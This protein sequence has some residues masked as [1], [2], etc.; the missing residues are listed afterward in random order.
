MKEFDLGYDTL[1][2]YL[3][4]IGADLK[5]SNPVQWVS[6]DYIPALIKRFGMPDT[7]RTADPTIN[8]PVI[9]PNYYSSCFG[10]RILLLD[11]FHDGCS[12]DMLETYVGAISK[13][14]FSLEGT[15]LRLYAILRAISEVFGVAPDIEVFLENVSYYF[16][17]SSHGTATSFSLSK[18]ERI[19]SVISAIKP[20]VV[21]VISGQV[22]EF[23]DIV[24]SGIDYG[25]V[26][27][28]RFKGNDWEVDFLYPKDP[29]WLKPKDLGLFFDVSESSY[30]PGADGIRTE[31]NATSS[32]SSDIF[33]L[34][35]DL[36]TRK[37]LTSKLFIN[38]P[39][40]AEI[41]EDLTKFK[42]FIKYVSSLSGCKY[43]RA[44]VETLLRI[45]TG[46]PFENDREEL[47][48]DLRNQRNLYYVIQGLYRG[49]HGA[50]ESISNATSFVNEEKTTDYFEGEKRLE[51]LKDKSKYIDIKFIDIEVVKTL[52][53]LYPTLYKPNT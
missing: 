18:E 48:W 52:N 13:N 31:E 37:E 25:Q 38:K 43:E 22:A 46:Y 15:A 9:G 10:K 42:K 28:K 45:L 30:I 23:F 6:T 8:L 41:K 47:I 14:Q 7:A 49:K 44:D 39:L 21:L 16:C 27:A 34:P 5:D 4:S 51:K 36:F 33:N 50:Y 26:S 11:G 3:N 2:N 40:P 17:N 1:F 20:Y 32:V 12:I 53:G 35:E 24:G 29:L 19:F